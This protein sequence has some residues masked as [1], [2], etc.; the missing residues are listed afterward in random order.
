MSIVNG[1]VNNS[2][3]S[4]LISYPI[5]GAA[6]GLGFMGLNK[7]YSQSLYGSSMND[8]FMGDGWDFVL[9]GAGIGGGVALVS[10]GIKYQAAHMRNSKIAEYTSQGLSRDSAK[11][12]A[13]SGK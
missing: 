6:A 8:P 7:M 9:T 1:L 10:A 12:L 4:Q 5:V 3:T 13:M 11:L 2:M